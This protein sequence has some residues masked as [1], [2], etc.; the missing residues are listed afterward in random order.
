MNNKN[1]D[2][3]KNKSFVLIGTGDLAKYSL[4]E[5]KK[6][7]KSVY[8]VSNSEWGESIFDLAKGLEVEYIDT[9]NYQEAV[10]FIKLN[11]PNIALTCGLKWILKSDILNHFNGLIFNYHPAN[12]P[13]YRGGGVF[14]WPILNG[15]ETVC[16]SIHQ[17]EIDVDAGGILL[18]N[19]R[20]LNKKPIPKDFFLI[21]A[22]L[23]KN[24][25]VDFFELMVNQ[26]E[27]SLQS[28]DQN[29]SLYFPLL[30]SNVNGAIDW[31]WHIEEI[32]SFI[33][34]FSYPYPGAFTYYKNKRINILEAEVYSKRQFHSFCAGL[35][36]GATD[37]DL[38]R[39]ACRNGELSINKI[40]I[41][42]V[43]CSPKEIFREG[44]RLYTEEKIIYR[45][46]T[47]RPS[48][49]D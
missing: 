12:L 1:I 4:K 39:V 11:N 47:F 41:D 38:V 27:V 45:A 42:G 8:L 44:E 2:I 33:R 9:E 22:E 25:V 7:F 28:Q 23:A 46:K 6:Y 20:K 48:N 36:I 5:A 31:G 35:I 43:N 17:I 29:K 30:Q 18:Q 13:E 32:E 24:T 14:S 34:A 21:S 49:K 19:K 16:V 3:P 37:K 26:S 15:E 40:E 10:D